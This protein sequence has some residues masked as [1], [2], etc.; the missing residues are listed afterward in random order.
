[1]L[2]QV[3]EVV[4]RVWP[5]G[6]ST[7]ESSFLQLLTLV[8]SCSPLSVFLADDARTQVKAFKRLVRCI[9][10]AHAGVSVKTPLPVCME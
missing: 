7:R 2:L 6:N 8:L 5:S 1:M 9:Q 3:V 10:S 4:L